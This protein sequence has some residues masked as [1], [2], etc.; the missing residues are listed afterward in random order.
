M[1]ENNFDDYKIIFFDCF[2]T[3][4]MIDFTFAVNGYANKKL[5]NISLSTGVGE[6]GSVLM[7]YNKAAFN[8]TYGEL[9][10]KLSFNSK[11]NV[12]AFLGFRSNLTE[13]TSVMTE[14][15]S[16]IFV[17]QVGEKTKVYYTTANEESQQKVEIVTLDITKVYEFKIAGNQLYYR[18][19][20]EVV[21][22]LGLPHVEPG[23]R[24]WKLIQSNDTYPPKDNL[25][26]ITFYI[27]NTT[28][29][30]KIINLNK[31]SYKEVHPD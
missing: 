18:P 10:F 16:G 4:E 20:P 3:S 1:A 14:S 21:Q 22:Y 13:P 17:E 27:K 5:T 28:N 2:L 23:S 24:E 19:V 26:Y 15:H 25:H 29:D 11:E 8:P 30:E 7:S 31:I 6:G 9:V 12:K